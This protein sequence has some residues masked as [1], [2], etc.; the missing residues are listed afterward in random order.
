MGAASFRT[1]LAALSRS[2]QL[3]AAP[4]PRP[5]STHRP[6]L[7]PLLASA[8]ALATLSAPSV[9]RRLAAWIYEGVLLF[10]VVML[11]GLVYGIA[12][13][14][15]H[16]LQ[17]ERGLQLF[18]FAA[19]GL[20]FVYFWSRHGQTLPMKTWHIR[21]V[22]AQGQAVAPW[23]AAL[24]YGLAWLWFLPALAALWA[25]GLRSGGAITATLV[26]GVLAYAALARLRPDR[27]F[28]HDVVCGTRLI[29]LR[30]PQPA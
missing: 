2:N 6:A 19:L 18:L 9:R 10:G 22:S 26:A 11:A 3:Y 1:Q 17:G 8:P 15:R 30:P 14:Q 13:Q 27:Q 25:S 5:N 23:R 24:R 7:L 29:D 20:Y 12:T 16:A 28:W 4:S 21:L